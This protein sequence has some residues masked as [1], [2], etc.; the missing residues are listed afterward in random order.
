MQSVDERVV[1]LRVHSVAYSV[2][3]IDAV[4]LEHSTPLNAEMLTEHPVIVVEASKGLFNLLSLQY[5]VHNVRCKHNGLFLGDNN[6][7]ACCC[8]DL[9]FVDCNSQVIDN[10]TSVGTMFMSGGY[11]FKVSL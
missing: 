4:S 8:W 7:L 10:Q 6:S 2:V 5:N 11:S 3:S 9:S 1:N